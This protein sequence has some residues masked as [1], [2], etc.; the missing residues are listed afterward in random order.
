MHVIRMD[1]SDLFIFN[2][3]Y[4]SPDTVFVYK[5][6]YKE[7]HLKEFENVAVLSDFIYFCCICVN[8]NYLRNY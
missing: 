3:F 1:A 5:S 7:K 4:F 2:I 8:C 6:I